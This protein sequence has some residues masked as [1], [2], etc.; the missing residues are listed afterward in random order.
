MHIPGDPIVLYN[1]WDAG[2]AS[3]VERQGGKAIATS[4]WSVAAAQGYEDGEAFPLDAMLAVVKRIV[5]RTNLPVTVDFEGG[6]ASDIETLSENL[7]SLLD[8]GVAGLNFEDQVVGGPGLRGVEDQS[9]RLAAIRR[10]ADDAGVPVFI[11][12]RTD[13]FLKSDQDADHASLMSEAISRGRAY[14]EA[15]ADGFFMPG[16]TDSSIIE[17]ICE[18]CALPI[19]VMELDVKRDTSELARLGVARISYGPAPYMS[20]TNA[21][22]HE[23]SA[24][25]LASY[26]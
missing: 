3:I 22:E 7:K 6:Y 11:N 26:E 13:L 4:S 15:G 8:L 5:E 25:L 19:N 2:S 10:T 24:A 16:L 1:I 9:A 23:A 20:L 18:N 17:A 14:R 12:A 21:L